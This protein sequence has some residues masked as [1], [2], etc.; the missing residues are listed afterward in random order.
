MFLEAWRS[1]C[2]DGFSTK[3]CFPRRTNAVTRTLRWSGVRMQQ[4]TTATFRVLATAV[5]KRYMLLVSF[6]DG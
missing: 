1:R 2:P 5:T 3:S 4:P 6:R